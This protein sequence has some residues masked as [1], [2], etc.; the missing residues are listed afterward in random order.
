MS[1]LE[2][3][4]NQQLMDT[5][6]YDVT[7]LLGTL[8]SRSAFAATRLTGMEKVQ[9]EKFNV[10]MSLYERLQMQSRSIRNLNYPIVNVLR[11][12]G[13]MV[14]YFFGAFEV[15]NGSLTPADMMTFVTESASL[16]TSMR[17]FINHFSEAFVDRRDALFIARFNG[18]EPTIGLTGKRPDGFEYIIPKTPPSEFLWTIECKDVT[19]W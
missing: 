3:K 4:V 13:E 15:A 16:I 6:Q 14:G 7:A 8:D 5:Q 1:W 2:I 18:V 12:L 10:V 9:K 19:F 11:Q 17:Y